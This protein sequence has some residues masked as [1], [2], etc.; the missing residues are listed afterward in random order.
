MT[1]ETAFTNFPIISTARLQLRPTKPTDAEAFFAMRRDVEI[2]KLFGQE[3]H[4]SLDDTR[5][6]IHRLQVTY[7]QRDGLFWCITLKGDDTAIG[8][9][10]FWNFGPGFHCV[11]MGYELSKKYWRQGIT[12]E[13]ASAVVDFGFSDLGVNR[14]EADPFGI[15]TASQNLLLKLGFTYE[16]TLRQRHFFRDHY[17]DQLYY[18]LLKEEW[19][20]T[21]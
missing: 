8:G 7:E 12:S 6:W 3:P 2:T 9:C 5:A 1:V 20:K 18:G 15:N 21:K 19:Q 16:G 13:A 10:C 14:I 17:E 4:L 11:E